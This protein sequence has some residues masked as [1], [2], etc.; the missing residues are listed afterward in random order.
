MLIG[1]EAKANMASLGALKFLRTPLLPACVS[2][3]RL[4]ELGA[5][6]LDRKTSNSPA[7]PLTSCDSW[8]WD[9]FNRVKKCFL[10]RIKDKLDLQIATV[11]CG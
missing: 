6:E 11:Q 3:P 5:R 8:E 7:L 9:A 10:L 2:T 4:R 1:S